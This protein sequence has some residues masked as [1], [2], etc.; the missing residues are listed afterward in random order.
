MIKGV[1]FD[2]GQTL[3]DSSDGFRL[4]EKD[5][6]IQIFENLAL[7]SWPEFLEYYR[8]L[9]QDF[10]HSSNF[11]RKALWES[12][13]LHYHRKVDEDFL[14]EAER[15]YWETVKRYTMIFPETF[16]VLQK[17]SKDY[18]L[19]LIT[20]TQG[21]VSDARHR[22]SLFPD[23]ERFFDVVIVAGEEGIPPKPHSSPFL[24]CLSKMELAPSEV[25][26]VGD[27]W[28]IDIRG[29]EDAGIQP[30]WL[31]HHTVRRTW[32]DVKT[33]TPVITSLEA[34]LTHPK[35]MG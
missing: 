19:G 16:D 20:N 14:L 7:T 35:I 5:A 11:S 13:Y 25:V 1:L 3:V 31:K 22:I 26:F 15:V 33:S 12:L 28:R 9:R 29:A 27:D 34:L 32:P 21:Q 10:H 23:L 18:K 2:F 4:A 8:G 17:L 24:L 6:Q 30:I